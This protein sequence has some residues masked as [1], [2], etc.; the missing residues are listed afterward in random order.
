MRLI[1]SAKL[2]DGMELGK[3]VY[4]L[5]GITLLKKGVTLRKSLTASIN[6]IKLSSISMEDR[7]SKEARTQ[8]SIDE[9]LK[10]QTVQKIKSLLTTEIVEDDPKTIPNDILDISV[11]LEDMM[12]QIVSNKNMVANLINLKSFDS[13]TFQHSMNVAIT[14]S[15]LGLALGYNYNQLLNLAKGALFHDV[16]KMLVDINILNKPGKL[17][18]EEFEEIK[19]HAVHG[20]EYAKKYLSMHEESLVCILQHHEKFNGQGYPSNKKENEIHRNAQIVAIADVYDAI[21]SKR[22]YNEPV[23]PSEA[24]EYIMAN[25]N[26]HFDS[27]IVDVFLKKVAVYPLGVCV[28]LSNGL[29]GLVCENYEGYILR[30][31]IKIIS[32]C[33][34]EDI[35]L[36]LMDKEN[37][38]ITIVEILC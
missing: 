18:K 13:Y 15:V 6:K 4:A 17:T 34:E 9:Q 3:I 19:G 2:K 10:Y 31:K 8:D 33:S 24:I 7:F 28:K 14:S 22:V 23:L 1:R 27:D 5:N 36:N 29:R 20:Y 25:A 35:Y 32:K 11:L 26:Y 16:G 12:D 21:T 30:P 38:A 37:S